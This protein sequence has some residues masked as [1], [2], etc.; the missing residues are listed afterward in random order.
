MAA[1]RW[2]DIVGDQ[3]LTAGGVVQLPPA[4]VCALDS[5]GKAE[6]PPRNR[7]GTVIAV[8]RRLDITP[9]IYVELL[10]RADSATTFDYDW[11]EATGS[12]INDIVLS[13]MRAE[14][15]FTSMPELAHRLIE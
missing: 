1:L 6:A 11:R 5:E 8:G 2:S 4:A 14:L 15:G 9:L 7:R 13:W 12:L 3:V 10:P